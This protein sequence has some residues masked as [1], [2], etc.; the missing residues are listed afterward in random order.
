MKAGQKE[1]SLPEREYIEQDCLLRI[2]PARSFVLHLPYGSLKGG[3][4]TGLFVVQG[5]SRGEGK[6][7]ALLESSS[8]RV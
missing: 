2:E 1:T 6:K 8:N 5:C 7:K 3:A 4:H